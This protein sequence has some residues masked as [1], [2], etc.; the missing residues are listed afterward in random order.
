MN[1]GDTKKAIACAHALKFNGGG[2][3]NHSIYWTNLAK[4]GGEPSREFQSLRLAHLSCILLI[5]KFIQFYF[6]YD[7]EYDYCRSMNRL[8]NCCFC[9]RRRLKSKW[10]CGVHYVLVCFV[11]FFFEMMLDNQKWYVIL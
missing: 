3:I 2:H 7:T 9:W 5:I 11:F 4:D 8:L 6:K 1:V 10:F